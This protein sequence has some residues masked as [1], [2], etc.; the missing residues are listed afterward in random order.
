[1][2][3]AD[4][5]LEERRRKFHNGESIE[6]FYRAERDYRRRQHR[7]FPP[8]RRHRRRRF[9]TTT[10]YPFIDLK[11]GGSVQGEIKALND[12]LSLS[13]YEHQGE[14]GTR[15]PGPW[16]SQRRARGHEYRDMVVIVRDRIQDVINWRGHAAQVKAARPTADYDTRYGANGGPDHRTCSSRRCIRTLEVTDFNRSLSRLG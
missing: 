1:M 4:T 10:Q 9:L 2:V 5:F 8:R 15:R 3:P 7:P 16:L 13:A 14:G 12:I 6:L 11:N